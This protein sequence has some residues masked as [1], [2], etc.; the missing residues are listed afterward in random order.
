MSS[1][2]I[3]LAGMLVLIV[4][5]AFGA[6]FA[7][8]AMQWIIVGAVVLLG[9]GMVTAVSRTRQKDPAA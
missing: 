9:I 6:Y 4:G 1:F 8:L 2:A 7:G 5:L 3:Y